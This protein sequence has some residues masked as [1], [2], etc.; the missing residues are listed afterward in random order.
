MEGKLMSSQE[1]KVES[2]LADF[3]QAMPKAE[4]HIHLEGSIRPETLLQLAQWHG[5]TEA[6]PSTNLQAL[7]QWFA[8][9]SFDHF[10]D[11]YL[12]IQD[13]LHSPED[14][15]LVTYE[16]GADM[17]AQNIIYREV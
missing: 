9:T 1:I 12:V 15:A 6:L 17:A 4:L 14:F 13:M 3:I 11:V 2:A 8:F 16:C 5:Q 7:R 10:L